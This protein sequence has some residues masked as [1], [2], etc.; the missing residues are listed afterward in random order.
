MKRKDGIK[1]KF[2]WARIL[3]PKQCF[4][5]FKDIPDRFTFYSDEVGTAIMWIVFILCAPFIALYFVFKFPI[6]IIKFLHKVKTA[7]K[8][9][10][11]NNK[12]LEYVCK[13]KQGDSEE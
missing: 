5:G 8:E 4:C 2:R 6:S 7:P 3:S 11:Q 9:A 10:I 13:I 12:R 1:L